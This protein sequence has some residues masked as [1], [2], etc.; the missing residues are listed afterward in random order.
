MNWDEG[1]LAR[2]APYLFEQCYAWDD[3]S[4][5]RTCLSVVN[6]R[7]FPLIGPKGCCSVLDPVSERRQFFGRDLP[8]ARED[9]KQAQRV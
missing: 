2:G 5:Q 3:A 4:N 9:T 1:R 8:D 7:P 6:G